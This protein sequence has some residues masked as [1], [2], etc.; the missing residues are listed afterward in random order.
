M[1]KPL[2]LIT[3]D[4]GIDSPGLAALAAALDGLGDLLIIAPAHQQ[5][6]MGRSMP[7]FYDGRIYEVTIG[8][9]GASWKAYRANVSPAQAVQ[10]GILELA[11]RVPSLAVSGINYGENVGTGVTVSGTVGAAMEAAAHGIP[12]L[13][14]SLQVPDPAMHLNNDASVDFSVAMYFT[15]Y[16]AERWLRARRPPEVDLLKIDIPAG[17]TRQTPW[18]LTRLERGAYFRP[19]KPTRV[20]L[21]EEWRLGYEVNR[22]LNLAADSDAAVLSQGMIS[23]TPLTI[24]ITANVRRDTLRALLEDAPAD[25]SASDA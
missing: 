6:G 23:V 19:L 15:R 14:V 17:A 16:F 8:L 3:N 4:D 1:A 24:D 20:R 11:D 7:P 21:D 2:I 10:Y 13:A 25:G 18:R 9:D 5:S 12:A 22:E